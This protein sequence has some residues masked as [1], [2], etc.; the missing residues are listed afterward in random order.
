MG[1]R[2]LE[3]IFSKHEFC[4]T[5]VAVNITGADTVTAFGVN[6]IWNAVTTDVASADD[7]FIP[8]HCSFSF[9]APVPISTQKEVLVRATSN[10][11]CRSNNTTAEAEH[12]APMKPMPSVI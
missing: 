4:H 5:T 10:I 8:D 7:F 2:K 3:H 12:G 9:L 1:E 11:L 6:Q